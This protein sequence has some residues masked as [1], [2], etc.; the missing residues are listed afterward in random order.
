[1][2]IC[3]SLACVGS[4][5]VYRCAR[6]RWA[7]SVCGY[8]GVR[9]SARL[10][11]YSCA[12]LIPW[13][14][15]VGLW[16]NRCA[17]LLLCSSV[18][19]AGLRTMDLRGLMGS[20]GRYPGVSVCT[21]RLWAYRCAHP[22]ACGLCGSVSILACSSV[23]SVALLVYGVLVSGLCGSVGLCVYV[24]LSGRVLFCSSVRL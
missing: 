6:P 13:S 9:S 18:A 1:M 20:V 3:S 16:I 7:S 14:R 4:L 24:E 21:A 5:W 22:V 17:R 23:A 10:W 8:V 12:C 19:S 2:I 15:S 11:V